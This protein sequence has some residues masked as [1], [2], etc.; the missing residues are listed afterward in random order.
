ML[1]LMTMVMTSFIQMPIVSAEEEPPEE[2]AVEY[3]ANE[4]AELTKNK[5]ELTAAESAYQAAY[6]TSHFNKKYVNSVDLNAFTNPVAY[7]RSNSVYTYK[8]EKVTAQNLIAGVDYAQFIYDV[9]PK[10]DYYVAMPNTNLGFMNPHDVV[11]T[12]NNNNGEVVKDVFYDKDESLL[13]I[14]KNIINKPKNK[15]ELFD[16]ASPV[17]IQSE[18]WVK[19]KYNEDGT[20]DYSKP[21]PLTALSSSAKGDYGFTNIKV[22][23]MF[24]TEILVPSIVSEPKVYKKS[25]FTIYLN[26]LMIPIEESDF[27]YDDKTGEIR[28][29]ASPAV[30]SSVNIVVNKKSFLSKLFVKAKNFVTEE[31]FASSKVNYDD[32]RFFKNTKGKIVYLSAESSSINLVEDMFV[33]WRGK[34]NPKIFKR[35]D[36]VSWNKLSAAQKAS[37][38]YKTT[39]SLL[40]SKT[41]KNSLKY[42]YGGAPT[43]SKSSLSGSDYKNGSE[44][45]TRIATWAITS[46]VKGTDIMKTGSSGDYKNAT[47]KVSSPFAS[48]KK[49]PYDWMTTYRKYLGSLGSSGNQYQD[50]H[51]AVNGSKNNRWAIHFRGGLTFGFK[52]P[53]K[54]QAASLALRSGKYKNFGFE[55]DASNLTEQNLSNWLAGYCVHFAKDCDEGGSLGYD[56]GDVYV[57]CIGKG[58]SSNGTKYVILAFAGDSTYHGQTGSGVYKFALENTAP[59]KIKKKYYSGTK[60]DWWD[61]TPSLKGA[62][63][64]IGG[65]TLTTDENGNTGTV[66]LAPGK[67]SLKETARPS[68]KFEWM[69]PNPKTVTVSA[70]KTNTFT[71]VD[72]PATPKA[73]MEILKTHNGN[74]EKSKF[75]IW[76]KKYGTYEQI[77]KNKEKIKNTIPSAV[78]T[79]AT[80]NDNGKVTTKELPAKSEVFSGEYYVHQIAGDITADWIENYKITLTEGTQAIPYEIEDPDIPLSIMKL[81][82]ITEE[83]IP[84]AG[85]EFRIKKQGAFEKLAELID[86]R[87]VDYIEDRNIHNEID[88]V[89]D[90]DFVI[91]EGVEG[92]YQF[93]FS[94]TVEYGTLTFSLTSGE[95]ITCDYGTPK[96]G[97]I[98][99]FDFEYDGNNIF[100]LTEEY[101]EP[102][103]PDDPP[104]EH[105]V[106]ATVLNE[107]VIPKTVEQHEPLS[108]DEAKEVAD[109]FFSDDPVNAFKEWGADFEDSAWVTLNNKSTFVTLADGIAQIGNVPA[110][111]YGDYEV[112]EMKGPE[113]YKAPN[114]KRAVRSYDTATDIDKP[115]AFTIDEANET[116]VVQVFDMPYPNIKT[117][118]VDG[119]T[120]EHYGA[121]A[122]QSQIIDT[123]TYQKV[124]IGK[125]YTVFG[126]L[127]DKA[128]GEPIVDEEGR[129]LNAQ[130]TFVPDEHDGT[131]EV[132]FD[133]DSKSIKGKDVVVF[134]KLYEGDE[135]DDDA[136]A[137]DHED[138]DD[139]A[140]TIP[141]PNG[142]TDALDKGTGLQ[143]SIPEQNTIIVDTFTYKNLMPNL[144]YTLKGKLYDRDTGEP[145]LIDGEEVTEEV[146]F[147]PEE[148]DGT[149]EVTFTIDATSLKGKSI[150]VGEILSVNDVDIIT[151]FDIEDEAQTIYFPEIRTHATED[152]TMSQIGHLGEQITITDKVTYKNLMPNKEYTIKGV[153]MDKGTGQKL[154]FDENGKVIGDEA[155]YDNAGDE[156]DAESEEAEGEILD[157]W[158]IINGDDWLDDDMD[159]SG[160]DADGNWLDADDYED[161]NDPEDTDNNDP[162]N[163]PENDP[164]DDGNG[165]GDPEDG[166]GNCDGEIDGNGDNEG[167]EPGEGEEPIDDEPYSETDAEDGEGEEGENVVGT[168]VTKEITFTP[169][170]RNGEIELKYSLDST[171]LK[172]RTIV[173][174]EK[175]Y[176]GDKELTSHEDMEDEEQSIYFPEISTDATDN[177]T[178]DH[179]GSRGEETK[180][181]DVV[182][183]NNLVPDKEYKLVGTLMNKETNEPLQMDGENVTISKTFTPK[184]ERGEETIEFTVD[185][186]ILAG[187]SVV[188]FEELY[189]DDLLVAIHTD[190]EDEDQTVNWP[191]LETEAKDEATDSH[192]GAFV[193][194]NKVKDTVKYTNL[195]T[196]REYTIKGKLM[197]KETGEPIVINDKE[198]TAEK[199]FTP[200]ETA[201]EEILEFEL[202]SR[203]LAGISVVAF[204]DLYYKDVL[205]GTHS[206]IEDDE[207][208]VWYPRIGTVASD[209]RT[210]DNV[211]SHNEATEIKD[212]VKYDNLLPDNEYTIKGRLVDKETGESLIVDGQEVT[213][214][215]TFTPEEEEGEEVMTFAFDSTD[216]EESTYVAFEEIY[217]GE[218]LIATHSDLEDEEQTVYKPSIGTVAKVND[219]KVTTASEKTVIIDTVEYRNLVP[220]KRYTLDG[221]LVV[222]DSEK[223]IASA[224]K[225][226]TAKDSDGSVEVKFV[227]N[228]SKL[229]GEE[230]VAFEK[231][232]HNDSL[233]AIH[234]DIDDES[235]TIIVKENPPQTGDNIYYAFIALALLSLIMGALVCERIRLARK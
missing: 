219:K 168:T 204:E 48:G 136:L 63:F 50:I 147:T 6:I 191:E 13:Y 154:M 81:D 211:M 14:K 87:Y 78:I 155:D 194:N 100:T 226:F 86:G 67:Y 202:D 233:I 146:E 185:S 127:M 22:N 11:V 26:G 222:K 102:D 61:K 21:L 213:A 144:E 156:G 207:Q 119:N 7:A 94:D 103:N 129:T 8:G 234:E 76:P 58:T 88:L 29:G 120:H 140:Q 152:D 32:M 46:Y 106:N 158:S 188:A 65:K 74:G 225:E 105:E 55:V 49:T 2:E 189:F 45:Y 70:G 59:V 20:P 16:E 54:V 128:T 44:N 84:Q 24:D 162:E 167:G 72:K 124:E 143:M 186:R 66:E 34:Y 117:N 23:N 112:Y 224:S 203:E 62:K 125:E 37:V 101:I 25:D 182:K 223:K 142:W 60:V 165:E 176:Y 183:Y 85:I 178:Q 153:L 41:W 18:Y 145:L 206:D 15:N 232:K 197:N 228:T 150:V 171:S 177:L 161:W 209:S 184:T 30:T 169:Q 208:T 64:T 139:E 172:G 97:T 93:S 175:L 134:E 115:V 104:I 205:I 201:G 82:A 163:D 196:D 92:T 47:T 122:A 57:A 36:S 231:M 230:I 52:F 159:T 192:I 212:V 149:E 68:T 31:V 190:I 215:K 174:F 180:V 27:E 157:W 118:A 40:K 148:K 69:S 110:A 90:N 133:V 111:Q 99:P 39:T 214:S 38:V 199:T 166:D 135:L 5:T 53:S 98:G 33:G 126:T 89:A 151:H 131:I 73:N 51:S 79:T 43:G 210:E 19:E 195:M 108:T 164:D 179:V 221:T 229:G 130:R 198:I 235:Q 138:I 3:T 132:P 187:K 17:A 216:F 28:I 10:S 116:G 91:Q 123:V 56:N 141:Y 173:V 75:L 160:L 80:S 220:G 193:E 42:L 1:L 181:T 83:P 170:E 121:I 77:M 218:T 95:S 109:M 35:D 113:G 107:G 96:S 114:Y 71:V 200:Q 217:Y 4:S 227:V 137:A 9:D 12:Y